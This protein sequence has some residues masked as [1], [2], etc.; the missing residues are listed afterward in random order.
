[1]SKPAGK[2]VFCGG[3]GLTKGHVWPE[4][5][6]T[7]LPQ[8]STHHEVEVGPQLFKTFTPDPRIK[9][10]EPSI[11]LHQGPARSRKPR[12]TC[13]K[14]NSGWMSG[15]ENLAIPY[16]V[17]LIR[18]TR[19]LFD[20]FGQRAVA[21]LLCLIVIRLEFLSTSRAVSARDRDSL[22]LHLWPSDNWKIWIAR[23]AGENQND[24]WSKSYALQLSSLPTDEVGPENCNAQITTLVVG[25][26]C[27]HIFYSA[28]IDALD[29]Y[30]GIDLSRL[31]PPAVFDKETAHLT[32]LS[33]NDVL[34]LHEAF[35]S[36]AP[37][38][39]KD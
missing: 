34:E 31:W 4:W 36:H 30:E 3:T 13:K 18:G 7:Y 11:H 29:G 19:F 6:G 21:N 39:P 5:F 20:T 32:D 8:I 1:M 14:C 24:N 26:L 23:Y 10:P 38:P 22:R 27:A 37:P 33:D 25:Q 12:N 9:S 15:I 28:V 2:C 35:A 16:A 17:P